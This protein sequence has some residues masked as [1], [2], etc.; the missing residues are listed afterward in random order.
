[1]N[2]IIVARALHVLAIVIW[3]GGVSMATTIVLPAVRRRALGENQFQAF[4]T[5]EHRFV[6][7]ARTA[8]VV[9]GI[10]GF[11]M[12]ARLEL[13]DRFRSA[14]FWWMHAMV[15][16]WLLF[17]FILFVVEPFIL[18]Q[19]FRSWVAVRPDVAFS[20]LERAHWILLILSLI[21]IFGAVAG[22]R[23]W[24]VF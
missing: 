14:D 23:G 24:P 5:I 4:Q 16:V 19:H 3:I 10:T 1:M 12:T 11:Y 2:D 9:V 22:S 21:T 18:H 15:C 20:W 7:Q 6:W 17:T 8:I 13:W